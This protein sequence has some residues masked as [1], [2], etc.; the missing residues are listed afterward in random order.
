MSTLVFVDL[1]RPT[2]ADRAQSSL[3]LIP[4]SKDPYEAIRQ[5]YL[6]GMNTEFEPFEGEARTPESPHIV[7]PPTCHVEESKGS[8]TFDARSTSSD[9]TT[10]L[11]PDHPLTHTTPV[12]VP[13][14]RRTACMVVCVLPVMLHGLS[15]G[16]A[17]V[18]A[19]SNSAFRKRFRS[20]YDSSPSSTISVRKR[21]RGTSELILG[22][23]SEEEDE[24]E[25]LAAGVEG[26]GVDDESYGLDGESPGVEDESHGLYD[27]NHGID[28]EGRG[29]ESDGLG[30]GEEEIVPKV[31]QRAVPVVETAVSKPLRLR[32]KA[33][34]HQELAL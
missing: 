30:L 18:A 32:Y 7:A 29:I 14:L 11:S 24:D 13:I 12:L 27:E 17:E 22:T 4:S 33:L 26:P 31:Q 19:M 34:R 10:P 3:V 6:V 8:G 16:M 20:S 21:Y 23:N 25:G 1:E 2:Q 5:A 9:S 15:V 28:G